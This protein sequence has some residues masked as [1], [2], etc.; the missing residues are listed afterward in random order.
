M[1]GCGHQPA[2]ILELL[3]SRNRF[4]KSQITQTGDNFFE[5]I[6]EINSTDFFP[7]LSEFEALMFILIHS[8]RPLVSIFNGTHYNIEFI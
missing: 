6:P 5:S 7:F 8:P 1:G 2:S 3:Q 4:F